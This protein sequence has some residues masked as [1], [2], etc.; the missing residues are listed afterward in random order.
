M[1]MTTR[2]TVSQRKRRKAMTM[3][4]IVQDIEAL[5]ALMEECT[6]EETGETRELSAEAKATF[7]DLISETES[8]FESKFD[9]I[10]RFFRNLQAEAA[11]SLAEKDALKA[12]MD[13]LSK[14]AKA[15]ENKASQLKDL[16]RDAL[17]RLKWPRYKT[18]L[19]SAGIQATRKSAKPTSTFDPRKV[20][21][22]YLKPAELSASAVQDAVKSGALYE[23]EGGHTRG[24]LY[25]KDADGEHE[26]AGVAYLGGDTL[27]I[28]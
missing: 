24:R 13:R 5:A 26:L 7:L 27:V 22:R 15:A 2:M 18:A 16:I 6:D 10:C 25:Y 23:K 9:N 1:R 11:V 14:H 12:E 4:N 19:F 3:Y 28:R 21:A 20:P 17:N 8:A